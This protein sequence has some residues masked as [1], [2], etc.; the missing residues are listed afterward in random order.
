[1]TVTVSPYFCGIYDF[2]T[3]ALAGS[4]WEIFSEPLVAVRCYK[5]PYVWKYLYVGV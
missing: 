1:M 3:F 2:R 4:H 5:N